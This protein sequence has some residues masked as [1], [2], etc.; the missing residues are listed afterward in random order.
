MPGNP[1]IFAVLLLATL[2]FFFWSASAASALWPRAS[3]KTAWTTCP[4][5]YGR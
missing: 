2:L 4:F 1:K 5:A 3:R